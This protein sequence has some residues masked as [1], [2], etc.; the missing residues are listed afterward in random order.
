MQALKTEDP[1]RLGA[2]RDERVGRLPLQG[3]RKCG[4]SRIQVVPRTVNVRPEQCSGRFYF[5]GVIV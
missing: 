1:A 2:T 3:R 5:L 4:L